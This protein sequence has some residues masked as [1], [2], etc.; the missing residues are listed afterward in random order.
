[1]IGVVKVTTAIIAV[2][3]IA[4]LTVEGGSQSSKDT[5]HSASGG[6]STSADGAPKQPLPFSHKTHSIA[7]I[8]C[9]FCHS[10]DSSDQAIVLP[11]A[12]VCMNCHEVIDK[13]K[14][15]I[16]E[17]SSF[18]QQ[19]RAIPWVHVYSVPGWVYW[20]H[21][22]HL[23]AGLECAECHGDVAKMEVTQA[24]KNVTTMEGC[25][26]CHQQHNVSNDCGSCH[27]AESP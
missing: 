18:A 5:G 6:D 17:L 13:D 15:A 22:P 23:H 25:T 21:T 1:M 26:S 10:S 3:S 4:L 27:E 12:A 24:A 7:E 8:N 9:G 19:H 11:S 14:P 16:Q 20:S 2:L